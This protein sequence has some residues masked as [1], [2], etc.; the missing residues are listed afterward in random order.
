MRKCFQQGWRNEKKTNPKFNGIHC[1][2][3]EGGSSG[4]LPGLMSADALV[5]IRLAN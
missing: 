1:D 5:K 4:R 3:S 2:A